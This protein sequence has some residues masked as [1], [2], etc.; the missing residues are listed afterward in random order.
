MSRHAWNIVNSPATAGPFMS[1]LQGEDW[2]RKVRDR[3]VRDRNVRIMDEKEKGRGTG[4]VGNRKGSVS[5]E[6]SR[7]EVV[8]GSASPLDEYIAGQLYMSRSLDALSTSDIIS[9]SI[10]IRIYHLPFNTPLY[11]TT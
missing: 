5:E 7:G 1:N 4:M 6:G 10:S 8:S 11:T 9:I 2:G 3:N